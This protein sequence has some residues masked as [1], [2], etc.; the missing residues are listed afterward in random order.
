MR[1]SAVLLAI[2]VLLSAHS[3]VAQTTIIYRAPTGVVASTLV[4]TMYFT[5]GGSAT[6]NPGVGPNCYLGMVC[7]FSGDTMY[8]QLSDGTT[9]T[10]TN[11]HGR[12]GPYKTEYGIVGGASGLD[13]AGHAVTVNYVDVIMTITCRSGRG[14]GCTKIYTGGVMSLTVN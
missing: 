7:G 9:A 4:T 1:I 10:L 2:F 5:G 3:A 13:S 14:G 6:L 11:F 12:F 8:Y